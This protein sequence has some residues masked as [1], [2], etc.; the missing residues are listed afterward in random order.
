MGCAFLTGVLFR[1]DFPNYAC[2]G[3]LADGI[4]WMVFVYENK[5]SEL[6]F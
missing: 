4:L 6:N 3:I 1:K 5:L 2:F